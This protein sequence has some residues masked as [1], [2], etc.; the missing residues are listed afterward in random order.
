[1][2]KGRGY[3][4]F[5]VLFLDFDC[6]FA[7]VEAMDRPELRGRPVVITPTPGPSGCCIT[8]NYEARAFGI[9]TGC[10][11]GE[12]QELCPDVVV[13]RA[14]PSRY[15]AVHHEL[16]EAIETAM[17]IESVDSVDECWGKLLANERERDAALR[18]ARSIKAVIKER[19]GP[20][21]CSIGIAPN[22]LLAKVAGSMQKPDGLTLLPRSDLP[23]PLL[24]LE[25]TDLP[26]IAKGINRRLRSKGITTIADLYARTPAQM[27]EAW[28]S[29]QGEY[30]YHWLRGDHLTGPATKR[31]TVGHQ[32]V[33]EPRMR[34]PDRAWGVAVRLLSKASQRMRS[35]DLVA[36]RI[37]LAVRYTDRNHWADWSPLGGTGD[38]VA[39]YNAMRALWADAP[40]SEVL[41][42]AVTLQ[43][44][45]QRDAQLPLFGGER[46]RRE[47]W[48]AIDSINA[49]CGADTV[50]MAPMHGERLT[51]PRRIPFGKPPDLGLAD[52]DE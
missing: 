11:A 14:R 9:K 3:P 32:H 20:I 36:G 42:I 8:S 51:A 44:L 10:R 47:L 48:D 41:M 52:V 30:W 26:G 43:D 19:V 18:I 4:E 6:Y 1:M 31:R 22:R 23:G 12:A 45:S 5:E 13:V 7:A 40:K 2:P 49:K 17:H 50:Y 25:L 21:T 39:M 15:I 38:T 27:R 37:T 16:I 46:D 33:L 34:K 29:V 28:G 35:M 24:D